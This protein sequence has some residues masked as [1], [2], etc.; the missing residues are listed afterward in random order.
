MTDEGYGHC[1][2]VRH[3][4]SGVPTSLSLVVIYVLPLVPLYFRWEE[5]INTLFASTALELVSSILS[6]CEWKSSTHVW[7]MKA[8]S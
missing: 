4:D 8:A 5:S 3:R 6:P 2:R 7:C 1:R